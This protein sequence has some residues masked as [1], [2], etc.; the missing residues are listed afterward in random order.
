MEEWRHRCI[1]KTKWRKRK[2]PRKLVRND[3]GLED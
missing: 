3:R 1:E 2:S